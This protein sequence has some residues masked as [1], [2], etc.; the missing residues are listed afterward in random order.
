MVV[1][2]MVVKSEPDPKRVEE[3]PS[4][5]YI[6]KHQQRLGSDNET[7]ICIVSHAI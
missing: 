3:K 5:A 4:G 6:P 7:V 1:K 2:Y